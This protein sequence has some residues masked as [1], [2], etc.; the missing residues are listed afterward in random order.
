[1]EA[2]VNADSSGKRRR[3]DDEEG[4]RAYE[5]SDSESDSVV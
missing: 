2:G 4:K 3:G 1:M 5:W